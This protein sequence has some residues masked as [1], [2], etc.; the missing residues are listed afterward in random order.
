MPEFRQ[1]SR[2]TCPAPLALREIT[3]WMGREMK[4]GAIR[5]GGGAAVSRS[6]AYRRGRHTPNVR[7][8]TAAIGPP[9]DLTTRR[10]PG[11]GTLDPS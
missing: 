3:T 5:P 11:F 2:L 8:W 4:D 7:K 9:C 10:L 6:A 1:K